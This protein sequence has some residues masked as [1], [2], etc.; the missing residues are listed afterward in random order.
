[1]SVCVCVCVCVCG[2]GCGCAVGQDLDWLQGAF[3]CF[4]YMHAALLRNGAHAQ[5]WPE[6]YT[7]TVYDLIYLVFSLPVIPFLHRMYIYIYIWF[8][9]TFTVC[10]W[11]S[12]SCSLFMA[13][14][15]EAVSSGQAIQRTFLLYRFN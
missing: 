2:C 5:G 14:L 7:Y 15:S 12:M 9:P 11:G 8:W 1:M 4:L 13:I 3:R 6:P 10:T